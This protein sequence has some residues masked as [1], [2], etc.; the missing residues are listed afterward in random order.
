MINLNEYFGSNVPFISNETNYWMIRTSSGIYYEEFVKNSYIAIGWNEVTITDL[1]E[2]NIS[3][4]NKGLVDSVKQKIEAS[5]DV[6]LDQHEEDLIYDPDEKGNK[7]IKA[8]QSK[9]LSQMLKFVYDLN[10]GDIVVI[11]SESS[12]FLSFGEVLEDHCYIGNGNELENCKFYKRRKIHW[13]K[14][15]IRRGSLDSVLLKFIYAHQT[16]FSIND[17]RD[18]INSTLYDF[19]LSQEKASLVLR[20]KQSS[21]FNPFEIRQFYN[22]LTYFI[23]EFTDFLGEDINKEN[24]EVKFNLQSPGTIVF[25]CTA[26]GAIAFAAIGIMTILAGGEQEQTIDPSTGQL[27]GKF[28]SNSLL[29]KISDFLDRKSLRRQNELDREQQRTFNSIEFFSNLKKME[30]APNEELK[31]LVSSDVEYFENYINENP[32]DISKVNDDNYESQN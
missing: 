18:Y 3:P 8:R 12:N 29:D 22:D 32:I 10:A 17:Y 1:H 6:F 27:K 20:I 23:E 24:I 30:V 31:Q 11:P 15:D 26:I 13:I 28:K 2:I 16:L 21:G 7:G 14:K 5:H 9:A 25:I 4:N 19:Y